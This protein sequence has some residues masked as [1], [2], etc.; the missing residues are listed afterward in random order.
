MNTSSA[1]PAKILKPLNPV[2]VS[3]V[4]LSREL[5][6]KPPFVVVMFHQVLAD[7]PVIVPRL[8]PARLLILSNDPLIRC[9]PGPGKTG[10]LM[11]PVWPLSVPG[12][13]TKTSCTKDEPV[14]SMVSILV[15]MPPLAPSNT[16]PFTLPVSCA[17]PVNIKVSAP[18]LP[19]PAGSPIRSA[20]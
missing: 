6:K 18:S 15:A 10:F 5:P 13:L 1:T 8:L 11:V 9:G 19:I 2:P 17:V 14:K 16:P 12:I 4:L 3:G 7:G 20:V